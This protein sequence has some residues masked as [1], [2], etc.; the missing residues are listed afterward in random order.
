MANFSR[1]TSAATFGRQPSYIELVK[2]NSVAKQVHSSEIS[3]VLKEEDE[4]IQI[5]VPAVSVHSAQIG[6]PEKTQKNDDVKDVMNEIGHDG[7]SNN[8]FQKDDASSVASSK[9]EYNFQE[10]NDKL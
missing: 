10:E 2:R 5:V 7:V 8:A 6:T 9:V 1:S 4:G 3:S